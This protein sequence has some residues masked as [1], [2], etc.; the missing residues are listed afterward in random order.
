MASLLDRFKD[1]LADRGM[2]ALTIE[3]YSRD[4]KQFFKFI[5]KKAAEVT[6]HDI[7]SFILHLR[8]NGMSASTTNRKLSSI[9]S[10]YKFLVNRGIVST[11]PA[12]SIETS[13]L[14]ESLPRPLTHNEISRLFEAAN[15]PREKVIL[16]ILYGAGLRRSELAKLKKEDI[17][18]ENGI[19]RVKG[20]GGR[21]RLVPMHKKGLSVIKDY[22][23]AV[24]TEWLLPSPVDPSDH[25]SVRQINNIIA[26]IGKRAGLHVTPHQFR[27][28]FVSHLYD[29][30][31]DIKTI[32]DLAGHKSLATTQKYAKVSLRRAIKEYTT[33]HPMAGE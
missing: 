25:L 18:I 5:N 17:D 13:K 19:I 30:G 27:H 12:A 4:I 6:P 7:T 28:S 2:S 24:Q 23:L 26:K 31:A 9:K 8:N 1:Y 22:V 16:H 11:N 10:F 3:N 29:A 32:G 14:E 15:T 20:K 21:E 33:H